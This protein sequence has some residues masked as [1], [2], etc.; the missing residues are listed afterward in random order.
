MA[1]ELKR[2]T[3]PYYCVKC[4]ITRKLLAY[5]DYYYEDT[6]DGLIV[7]A[8]YYYDRKMMKKYEEAMMNPELN[9]GQDV[10]SYKTMLRQ[11][12]REFLDRGLLDRPIL[13]KN[14][15]SKEGDE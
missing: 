5:G 3:D 10:I 9:V 12:E 14:Y 6:E 11:K 2:I 13:G 7:D 15:P 4:D 8:N 1:L